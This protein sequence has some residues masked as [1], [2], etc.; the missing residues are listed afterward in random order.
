MTTQTVQQR[1]IALLSEQGLTVATGESLTAG[2]VAATLAEVPGC[3]AVLRGGVVAYQAQ[4]KERLLAVPA[5]VLEAG[6]V[7]AEVARALAVGARK[8]LD[9]DV[10]I[11]TTG[12]AGPEPHDGAAPGTAWVAVSLR[13]QDPYAQPCQL[14]GNRTHIRAGVTQAALELAAE[15]LGKRGTAVRE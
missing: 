14:S 10:G 11:G 15:V 3:S 5:P 9:A 8:A 12:A 4:V 1:V 13:G 7:S 2:Q 6:M